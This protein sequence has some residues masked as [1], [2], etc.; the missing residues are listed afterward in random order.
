MANHLA[1]QLSPYLLQHQDNPVD[2][3]P[4]GDEAIALARAQA[5]PILLSIGYAACHWCH[6]MAHEC[7]EDPQ[8]ADQ[9]NAGFVNIKVDREE[10]PDLDA[11][12]QTICQITG[13]SGGWPLTVFLTPDLKPFFVGTYF[14]PQPRHGL[15]ALPQIL[16]A[17]RQAWETR[18]DEV[19]RVAAEWTSALAQAEHLE[20]GTASRGTAAIPGSVAP[21]V[22]TASSA[23]RLLAQVDR[24]H[25]GFGHAPKFPNPEGLELLVRAGGEARVQALFTL[26]QMAKGG[27]YDQLGGGFHRYSVDAAWQVPHFEKML[28]DNAL[29][30]PLYLTGW[31]LTGEELFARVARETCGFLLAELAAPEGGFYGTLDAD[32]EGEEGRFYVW[33]RAE[34]L[35]VAGEEAAQAFGVTAEGNFEGG[36]TVLQRVAEPPADA[37]GKLL[38]ARAQRVR[39]GR[40]EKILTGWNG[41]ALG[42]L[43]QA[44]RVLGNQSFTEAAVRTA[45]FLRRELADGEDGLL[46]V[47]GRPIKGFLQDYAYLCNGLIDLYEATFDGQWVRWAMALARGAVARFETDGA[48]YQ[49]EAGLSDLIHRPRDLL[50][51]GTPSGE[52]LMVRAL[53]RLAAWTGDEAVA[54]RVLEARLPAAAARPWGQASL[55]CA[56]DFQPLEVTVAGTPPVAWLRRLAERYLP[57]LVLSQVDPAWP[58]ELPALWMGKAPAPDG[59]PRAWVCRGFTCSLALVTWE[60]IEAAL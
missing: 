31:Q 54:R 13:R 29:L 55:L 32:S 50:D 60:Q 22:T 30:P 34:V 18:R 42:A 27:V 26:R 37:V 53:L 1:G 20:A 19:D 47:H 46:H 7:F 44:G 8:I 16:G 15:P 38:A 28:Y 41:L 17:V 35:R 39:P 58:G 6:V 10:R 12:Y 14:P 25:G 2:W 56:A 52:S 51:S 5:K 21:A 11:I 49:T 4:W 48:F 9:M 36:R 43:A 45:A 40:D 59:S 57:D 24:T 3:H 23:D 33:S